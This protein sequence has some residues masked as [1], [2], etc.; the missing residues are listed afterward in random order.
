M[1]TRNL[2]LSLSRTLLRRV[3]IL[4]A[5][6]DTSISALLTAS[7]EAMVAGDQERRVTLRR[8][9]ARARRGYDLGSGGPQPSRRDEL[10]ER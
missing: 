10:H 8:L 9:L 3:K 2:T 1:E 5:E 4:A 7:L 6:R